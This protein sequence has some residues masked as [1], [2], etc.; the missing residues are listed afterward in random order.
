MSRT[1]TLLA[2]VG[3]SMAMVVGS[4]TLAPA[5]TS[6]PVDLTG[7]EVCALV[8]TAAMESAVA[9]TVDGATPSEGGTPQCSYSY[10]AGSGTFTNVA[11]AVMR[12]EDDL[13]GRVGAKAFKYAV[14]QNKIYAGKAKFKKLKGLGERAVFVRGSTRSG[15]IVLHDSGRVITIFGS[16]LTKQSA[17][18]I[19]SAAVDG[20]A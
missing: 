10:Q 14:A 3:T 7:T 4:A 8:D 17:Q 18:A 2:I 5:G 6:A 11:L 20:L 19:A 9:A 16:A 13:G 15:I 1:R 12:V